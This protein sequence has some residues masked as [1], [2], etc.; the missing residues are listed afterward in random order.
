[1]AEQP[2]RGWVW[3][4]QEGLG[5]GDGGGRRGGGHGVKDREHQVTSDLSCLN[6]LHQLSTNLHT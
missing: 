6:V 5:E 2:G 3:E 1:M 4:G